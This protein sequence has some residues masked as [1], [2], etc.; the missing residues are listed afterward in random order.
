MLSRM[1][2]STPEAAIRIL[3]PDPSNLNLVWIRATA[4]CFV[5]GGHRGGPLASTIDDA[6]HAPVSPGRTPRLR[7][8]PGARRRTP[9]PHVPPRI[10]GQ[11]MLGVNCQKCD[12]ETKSP[13]ADTRTE[14]TLQKTRRRGRSHSEECSRKTARRLVITLRRYRPSTLL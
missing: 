14:G 6:G 11:P 9:F 13:G 2:V 3:D 7:N 1:A 4:A 12:G 8:F 5:R 10:A